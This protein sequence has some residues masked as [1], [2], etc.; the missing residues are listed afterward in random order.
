MSP[1]AQSNQN[2][3]SATSRDLQRHTLDQIV[4]LSIESSAQ[5]QR[6]EKAHLES[7][8]QENAGHQKALWTDQQRHQRRLTELATTVQTRQESVDARY[9]SELETIQNAHQVLSSQI[10][11]QKE[12]N[13]TAVKKQLEQARWLAE[14][15]LEAIETQA[16]ADDRQ[17]HQ[18][19]DARLAE[20]AGMEAS[21]RSAML[22]YEMP[23]FAV[24]AAPTDAADQRLAAQPG[25]L[26]TEQRDLAT[27]LLQQLHGLTLPRLMAGLL[28]YGMIVLAAAIF[29][30][31]GWMLPADPGTRFWAAGAAAAVAIAAGV[32]I[33][34]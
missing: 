17:G 19:H 20:V 27:K 23:A 3:S 8:D 33:S 5:E 32:A 21:A 22:R 15:V 4:T 26:L 2:E 10:A 13:D 34:I 11:G 28:P 18:D 14:S 1:N 25:P 24:D 7:L 9:K 29:G 12:N 31:A 16:D 30:A 6:I